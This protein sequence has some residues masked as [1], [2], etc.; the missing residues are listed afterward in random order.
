MKERLENRIYLFCLEYHYNHV[1]NKDYRIDKYIN[2]HGEFL[3]RNIQAKEAK[4]IYN[5][6]IKET[7]RM[8]EENIEYVIERNN[9]N[10]RNRNSLNTFIDICNKFD[11][12]D[13]E[14]K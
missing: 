4:K 6:Y 11:D 14:M 2:K 7:L 3:G 13:Y 8:E 1:I 12:V 5:M 9:K 10:K